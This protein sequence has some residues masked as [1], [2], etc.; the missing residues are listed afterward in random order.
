M[1]ILL[2][3]DDDILSQILTD[4]L[5]TQHYVVDTAG[6]GVTGFNYAQAV[7]YDLIVLDVNLPQLDGIQLCQRLR[8]SRY[9]APILLLT[10]KGES[11]DKVMGLDAGAD[12]YVVKPCTVEE[13]SARMR[14]LLRRPN[15]VGSPVLTWGNLCLDPVMCEVTCDGQPLS[16]SPKEY[17]L[18]ELFLRNPQR[19]FSSGSILEHLWSFEDAPS[20]ETIRSHIKRLRR[21]LKASGND[22]M[23]DTVYGMGYR[24]KSAFPLSVPT[25]SAQ[26][27]LFPSATDEQGSKFIASP[28]AENEARATAIALWQQ[29]KQPMLDR[30]A[31]L[32]RAMVALESGNLSDPIRQDAAHA[33]H[34]LAGSIAMFGFPAATQ[35]G[36]D[37]E[38]LLQFPDPSLTHFKKL[39][40]E[41]QD[42]LQ[43]PIQETFFG[44]QQPSD[45]I[46]QPYLLVID[47]DTVFTQQLQ[48]EGNLGN[49]IKVT[50]DLTEAQLLLVTDLPGV[51]LI[52]LAFLQSSE[53]GTA[54]LEELREQF[55]RIPLVGLSYPDNFVN[56]LAGIRLGCDRLIA[57]STPLHEILAMMQDV[58]NQYATRPIKV[59]AV[60]DDPVIL[61][62][63]N[64][65][66]PLQGIHL[67]VVNTP[68][69][70][71]YRLEA[72]QPDLVILDV[73]MPAVSGIEL[74]QVI[75][76]DRT[77]GSLPILFLT[78]RQEPEV[79]SQLYK[80]GA[81]DYVSKP[82]TES[83][84]V[85][86]ILNRLARN[87][88]L[89]QAHSTI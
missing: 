28:S 82:F 68:D 4:H 71:W 46:T 9:T 7:A 60:D 38:Q 20:E 81:D 85:T 21:K 31:L 14:A 43:S 76:S 19:T 42:I 24:L 61:E 27:K 50:S 52:D 57:K 64:Q 74:C 69:A 10:A 13:I 34:K 18:L 45:P 22:D 58:L 35:L 2:V 83:E 30:I 65:C 89:Q 80:A 6:D 48:T 1:R 63:L 32:N 87:R 49:P 40:D 8:Q 39:L 29:F 75:R 55:S 54:F 86:R 66:L 51:I 37:L 15:L 44:L 79:I 41:L 70:F 23:I 25:S 73:E 59:L 16:L 78:A 53:D 47:D 77:W 67:T 84:I 12:D 17:S 36:R 11:S 33:A 62:Q 72:T 56:R 26:P 3:E 5:T 88:L